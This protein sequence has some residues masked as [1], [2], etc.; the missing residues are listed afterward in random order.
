MS[1]FLTSVAMSVVLSI[2]SFLALVHLVPQATQDI[3]QLRQATYMIQSF[4]GQCSAV[5]IADHVMLTA[6][7]CDMEVLSTSDGT[8][9]KKVKIDHE[10]DLMLLYTDK[11]CPCVPVDRALEARPGTKLT[12]VGFPYGSYTNVMVVTEG[13]LQGYLSGVEAAREGL[14]GFML[15]TSPVAPGN[16]GGGVF[17]RKDGQWYVASIVSRG[18]GHIGVFPSTKMLKE[19]V[20]G[21]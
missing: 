4:E 20:Y 14:A 13:V 21:A 6:A 1:K 5:L 17:M 8:P 7:H 19:F 2:A 15:T 11:V 10:R 3:T 16:S 18:A 12:V 9:L